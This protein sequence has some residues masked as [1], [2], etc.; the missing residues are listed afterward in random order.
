M[1]DLLQKLGSLK[2]KM[3]EAKSRLD[4]VSVEGYAGDREVVVTMT[5]NRKLTRIDI[6]QHLLLPERKEEVEEL[7]ETAMNRALEQ[8]EKVF[9]AEMKSAGRDLLPGMPF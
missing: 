9:E 5:G 7:I 4:H 1:L 6:A 3:E 2:S 8:A